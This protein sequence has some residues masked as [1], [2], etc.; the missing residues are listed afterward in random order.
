MPA[1]GKSDE[2]VM[3][4]TLSAVG[5]LLKTQEWWDYHNNVQQSDTDKYLNGFRLCIPIAGNDRMAAL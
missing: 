2:R 1:A 5:V 3:G 4:E